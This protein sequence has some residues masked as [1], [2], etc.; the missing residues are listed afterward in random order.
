[1]H[2]FAALAGAYAAGGQ[3]DKAQAVLQQVKHLMMTDF[4]CNPD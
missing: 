3:L 1:M 2:T 4:K